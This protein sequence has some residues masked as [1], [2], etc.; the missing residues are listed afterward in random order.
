MWG[1]LSASQEPLPELCPWT[2]LGDSCP[3]DLLWVCPPH[4]KRPSAAY[5]LNTSFLAAVPSSM[6]TTG[7][8]LAASIR[9]WLQNSGATTIAH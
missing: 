4:P 9:M 8:I 7:G 1:T 6:I 5:D 2:P 3:P